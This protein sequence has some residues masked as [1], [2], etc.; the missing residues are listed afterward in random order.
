[1]LLKVGL[2]HQFNVIRANSEELICQKYKIILTLVSPTKKF[3]S[4]QID[5]LKRIRIS[6]T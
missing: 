3:E 4:V 6:L 1:M 5:T 2:L